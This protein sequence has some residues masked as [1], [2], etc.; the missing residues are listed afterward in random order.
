MSVI[1]TH[2]LGSVGA[3]EVG[4]SIQRDWQLKKTG[5]HKGT[6]TA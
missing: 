3:E 6:R 5:C 2:Q 1:E 4:D